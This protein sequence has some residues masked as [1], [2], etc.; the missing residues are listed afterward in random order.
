MA[1]RVIRQLFTHLPVQVAQTGSGSA[2]LTQRQSRQHRSP[3]LA[4]S[5][6]LATD[7]TTYIAS[8]AILWMLAALS[9]KGSMQIALTLSDQGEHFLISPPPATPDGV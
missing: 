2:P 3:L 4:T 7:V 1:I 8:A 9:M 6:I 5:G